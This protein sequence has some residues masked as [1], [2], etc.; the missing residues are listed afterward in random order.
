[1]V[2]FDLF[3]T[4]CTQLLR[5]SKSMLKLVTMAFPVI[6]L[7]EFQDTNLSQWQ[8]IQELGKLCRVIALADPDQMIYDFLGADPSRIRNYIE[9]FNP[10][11]FDFGTENNRSSGTDI[12]QFGND[13]L[14][15]TNKNHQYKDVLVNTYTTRRANQHFE[16]I[17]IYALERMKHLR[18]ING[19][20]WSIAILVPSNSLMISISDFLNQ[21]QHYTNGKILPKI[22]HNVSIDTAGPYLAANFIAGILECISMKN[23]SLDNMII[24][25]REYILGHKGEDNISKKDSEFIKRLDKYMLNHESTYKNI[26]QLTTELEKGLQQFSCVQ[27][28]GK[29]ERDWVM[30]RNVLD[31]LQVDY[32]KRI[33]KDAK[34]L[35]LLHKGSILSKALTDLW[36]QNDNYSNALE[37][38]RESLIH[39]HFA[40]STQKWEGFHLMTIHKAKGKE[41][42]EVIIFEGRYQKIVYNENNLDQYRRNLRVAVTR[43]KNKATIFTSKEAPCCLL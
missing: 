5:E 41:F 38:V 6:I 26:N 3:A 9:N 4:L 39:E 31:G 35:R 25:L 10:T 12:I 43:A 24:N 34:A 1:M 18:E 14:S 36:K 32:I 16:N 19:E 2:H 40:M 11:L 29:I 17:K 30:I 23:L 28:T 37:V 33:V 15:G 13:L 22:H 21:E 42:D 20:N 7:D 27:L 8:A